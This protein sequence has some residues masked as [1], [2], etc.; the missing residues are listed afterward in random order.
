[1]P[2]EE[3]DRFLRESVTGVADA[4]REPSARA[5]EVAGRLREQPGR[6]EAW[7]THTLPRRGRRKGWYVVG[8]V[9]SAVLLAV[10]LAPSQV[11][12]LVGIGGS[13][14]RPLAAETGNPDQAPPAEP[15]LR[16]TLDEPFKGSPA[17]RWA[18]G[19]AGITVP[20]AKATGWMSAGQVGRA[21][22]QSRAFLVSSSLDREVLR[23]VRPDKAITLINPHQQDTQA[24]LKAS[25]RTPSEEN[26][27]LLLFSRFRA[28]EVRLVGDVVKT[29]G[30]LTYGEGKRGALQVT[31]DVTFVYPV[32]R[33]AAGSDEVVRTI[34]RR[35]VVM[36]WDNPA[37][38]ITEPG[39]FSLVSYKL[40][41]TNGG[42][43]GPTGFL[44]PA[45]G[46]DRDTA[47]VGGEVDPYDRSTPLKGSG[48]G[49][50]DDGCRTATRS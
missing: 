39:T 35:E 42:C 9:A 12:G 43:G 50:D 46:Q 36:S 30:R 1:M 22:E 33:A 38:V 2:D 32:T 10:A 11:G 3:W 28:S 45:F 34:V 20:V 14:A 8:L 19:S 48:Q 21:L 4:P 29:R 17:A 49:A 5:R 27:P 6:P 24:Y 18:S 7:R 41:M 47:E 15:A 37:K 23:G 44:T 16:P 40:D 13:D 31:A 25:F 26:D